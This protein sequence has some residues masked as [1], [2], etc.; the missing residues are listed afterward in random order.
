M[1]NSIDMFSKSLRTLEFDKV[2][3]L[4]AER[5]GFTA[6]KELAAEL[7]P[8]VDLDEVNERLQGTSEARLLLKTNANISIGG[9]RDVRD[10]VQSTLRGAVLDPADLLDIKSTLLASRSLFRTLDKSE[11][12]YPI[13]HRIAQDLC[14]APDLISA[15]GNALNDR[16]E[17]LESASPELATIRHDLR[18]AHERL[19]SKLQRFLNNPKT[20]PM[21]QES[22]ITQ[23][24]GRSVIPLR[25]EFKGQIKAVIHDQSSSGATLFIEPLQVVELNNTVREL[26]LAERDEIRRILA[27]LSNRVAEQGEAIN[28]SVS[29]LACLDLAFAKAKLAE[30]M[31]A[32]EPQ[33]HAFVPARSSQHP[34][35]ILKLY[36]ARHPLLDPELVVPIDLVLDPEV[37]VLVITGPNTG[38]KTVTLKTTGLMVLMAQSGLHIPTASG[39][40]MSVFE[41]VYCDIG[42][43]QSIEQSLS[44]F[45]SH[46]SNIIG[47]LDA[48]NP[49]SLV[50]LDELGAGTDPQE[51]SALARALLGA[52]VSSGITTLV[53]THFPELKIYAHNTPGVHNASVE[54]DLETLSPTY[55]LHIGI[56]GQ[57][58]A[59]AIAEKLGLSKDIIERA[60][61]T[62]APEELQVDQLLDEIRTQ[63]DAAR[64]DRFLAETARLEIESNQNELRQ[65][66]EAIEDER[67]AILEEARAEAEKE[68]ADVREELKD[69]RRRL[70]KAAQPLEIVEEVEESIEEIHEQVDTPLVRERTHARK[71]P[72][73]FRLGDRVYVPAIDSEGVITTLGDSNAEIQVGRLR[74]RAGLQELMLPIPGSDESQWEAPRIEGPRREVQLEAP[75]VEIHLRGMQVDDALEVLERRL[76]AAFLS[77]MPFIRVVHGK[78]T[79]RLR[80]AVRELLKGNP[81]VASYE[82]GQANEG[83]D[84]VTVVRLAER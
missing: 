81:Y 7:I 83:G 72:G 13:L 64:E 58:N 33:M 74:I 55:R 75:P 84:G 66:L 79:G 1:I 8:S 6:S 17:I 29:A 65:R 61:G 60:R 77:G 53:A 57:S 28:L 71:P 80:D 70:A 82:R 40:E 9:A 15:I 10:R 22:I 78:G 45:S 43:E 51:G 73:G 62:I 2:L 25:S 59:L 37:F 76:D 47:I 54:F 32:V 42:D 67:L 38:G 68:L 44:T 50:L 52:F 39:S 24:E 16:G 56:P 4:L 41:S 5:T 20:A 18:I 34:G 49:R 36:A 63:R 30:A 19:N 35:G 27:A 12:I 46:I 69:L 3:G 21:L 14:I 31:D 11:R 26:E 48:T 23:R